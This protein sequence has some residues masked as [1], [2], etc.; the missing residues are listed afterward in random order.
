MQHRWLRCHS[1]ILALGLTE[2]QN[3]PKSKLYRVPAPQRWPD[4]G[5]TLLHG[6]FLINLSSPTWSVKW[7]LP[8][9]PILFLWEIWLR[10][11]PFTVPFIDDKT[12]KVFK[13][14]WIDRVLFNYLSNRCGLFKSLQ[15][16]I[17]GTKK[18]EFFLCSEIGKTS[19]REI[20][21]GRKSYCSVQERQRRLYRLSD[22]S[23][24]INRTFVISWW[25]VLSFNKSRWCKIESLL[26]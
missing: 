24:V 4:L 18:T 3:P 10:S 6:F 11:L 23:R 15:I 19:D 1:R 17:T 16:K 13:E 12:R 7:E 22:C 14:L 9:D 21:M 2:R 8:R 25:A 26:V 5:C 20:E